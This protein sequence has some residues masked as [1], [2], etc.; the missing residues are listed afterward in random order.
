MFTNQKKRKKSGAQNKKKK[1][2]K[3]LKIAAKNTHNIM[4]MFNNKSSIP[5][6][7]PLYNN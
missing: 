4:N 3:E 1:A 2:R 5:P 7:Q 6:E